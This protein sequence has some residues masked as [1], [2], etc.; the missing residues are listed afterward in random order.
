[1]MET[2]IGMPQHETGWLGLIRYQ[3]MI[4]EEQSRQPSP[5]NSMQ[6]AVE[7]MLSLL[8]E[9]LNVTLR[10][11]TDF[12]Q[13]FDSVAGAVETRVDIS[14]YRQ[15]TLAMNRARRSQSAPVCA[16]Q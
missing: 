6:D 15:G 8:A 3:L 11:R 2:P 4:A 10:S 14:G 1:M 13:L 16:G 5:L 7:S 12:I 9:H